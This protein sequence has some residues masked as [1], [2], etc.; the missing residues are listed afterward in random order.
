M[1][2]RLFVLLFALPFAGVGV[3]LLVMSV[4]PT[5]YDWQRMQSWD[6]VQ[7]RLTHAR[8]IRSSGEG[9]T[10]RPEVAYQ[11]HYGGDLY[12]GE[13][14]AINTTSDNI[15]SFQQK[16]GRRLQRN[17]RQKKMISIYVNPSSPKE[18]VI[19][20]E[21]RWGL[22]LFKMM[23]VVVFGGIGLAV[24]YHLFK[25][26]SAEEDTL[27]VAVEEKKS[28]RQDERWQ[29]NQVNSSN[30]I[31]NKG[32]WAFAI[33][34]NIISSPLYFVLPE[35]LERGNY[36]VLIGL[37]FPLAGAWLLYLAIKQS[38]EWR[39]FG[40]TPLQMQPF[41][42]RIGDEMRGQIEINLPYDP[43]VQFRVVLSCIY[44]YS[45]DD[46]ERER[47]KW[48]DSSLVA[49]EPGMQG[50]RVTVK[51]DLPG[52]MPE[53]SSGEENYHK[54][55]LDVDA[56]LEGTD[57]SRQFEIPVYGKSD[58]ASSAASRSVGKERDYRDTA[59]DEE[60]EAIIGIQHA[61]DG[62]TWRY[63]V[64]RY[65]G[66][67]FFVLVFGVLS[68]GAAFAIGKSMFHGIS[69]DSFFEI[70][71]GL[72]QNTIAFIMSSVFGLVG[73]LMLSIGIYL[74]ANSLTLVL[75]NSTL[76]YQ[77][78]VLGVPLPM[79][80]ITADQV[81]DIKKKINFTTGSGKQH[82]AN[83][84]VYLVTTQAKDYT[85]AENIHSAREADAVRNYFREK[86]KP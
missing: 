26:P 62:F 17:Y 32:M 47:L 58:R 5:L 29:N 71:V 25:E 12:Y 64:L 10:Y 59:S 72:F 20:R 53:S 66:L 30:R 41:P 22:L 60:I 65:P 37:V 9:T 86:L 35:E 40:P 63:G 70:G 19:N 1:K 49:S 11:Y 75:R 48:Q 82:K 46:G 14:A 51:F 78:R 77:R 33:V 81:R 55:V 38:L 28:W 31:G 42:A 15:G 56:E 76:Y 44:A 34:W 4:I 21:L 16:L 2:E 85:L 3:G 52:D 8:L 27:Q 67:G 74:V 83:Y 73:L 84:R 6:E 39:R 45:T 43:G 7:A 69:G 57:Y 23:F 54:W 50:T 36:A 13:R 79:K 61:A 18:S 80:T 24:L 68:S